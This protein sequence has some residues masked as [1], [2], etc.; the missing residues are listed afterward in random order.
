MR[1]YNTKGELLT[2]IKLDSE[3]ERDGQEVVF[4]IDQESS[5][6]QADILSVLKDIKRALSKMSDLDFEE[7]D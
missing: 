5:E 1:V 7:K 4:V 6:R 3:A 2:H